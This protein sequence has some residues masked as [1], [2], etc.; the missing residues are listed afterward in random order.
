MQSVNKNIHEGVKPYDL[1]IS[2]IAVL[3]L[4]NLVL[5]FV[6]DNISILYVVGIMDI[7]LSVFFLFDFAQRYINAKNKHEYF[8][9]VFGWADMLASVPLPQFKLLRIFRLIKAYRLI[10]LAGGKRVLGEFW[11]NRATGALFIVLFMI[12]L[13][14]EFGSI[15]VLFAEMNNPDAN[16]KA[17]ADAVWW[18]YVTITTVGYGDQ[19]PVTVL[20]RIV[21]A[22][23]MLVGVGLFGVVTGY[24]ANKFLPSGEESPEK[25]S[26]EITELRLEV[27]ELQTAIEK[28]THKL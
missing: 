7:L 10:R 12:I 16:I 3:S 25:G 9:K 28:L 13:L 1:F 15:A 6:I 8:F 11:A 5:Y 24:L 18:T 21:G 26:S 17:A 23:V 27:K 19:Y 20:G 14:L 22:V 2:A 4:V